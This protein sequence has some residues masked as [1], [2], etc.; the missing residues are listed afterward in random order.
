MP[1]GEAFDEATFDE[2]SEKCSRLQNCEMFFAYKYEKGDLY[3]PCITPDYP[4]YRVTW[5]NSDKKGQNTLYTKQ[6]KN[7]IHTYIHITF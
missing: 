2:A 1:S 7:F 4:P 3:F 6:G 5:Q